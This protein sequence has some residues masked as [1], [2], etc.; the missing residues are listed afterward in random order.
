MMNRDPRIQRSRRAQRIALALVVI[1]WQSPEAN[2]QS[3]GRL[4]MTP[5]ERAAL[6]AASRPAAEAARS[7]TATTAT[8]RANDSNAAVVRVDGL[9]QRSAGRAVVW[10]NGAPQ[11][12]PVAGGD[13]SMKS[14][15]LDGDR[16][17]IE[18]PGGGR[19]RLRP[20]ESD[21]PAVNAQ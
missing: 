19:L 8:A 13:S 5:Q 9:M 3:L 18:Q 20:G 1:G 4:F 16:I 12:L 10:L 11:D 6:D 15:R 14:P 21:P 7:A 17:V 2:A